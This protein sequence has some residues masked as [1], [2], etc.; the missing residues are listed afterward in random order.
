[1]W[2]HRT[3]IERLLDARA[4]LKSIALQALREENGDAFVKLDN[5]LYEL[6]ELTGHPPPEPSKKAP[7]AEMFD[8]VGEAASQYKGPRLPPKP[9]HTYEPPIPGESYFEGVKRRYRNG[10]ITLAN[11]QSQI[12]DF[13][14]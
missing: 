7:V 9:A 11:V 1:M 13:E 14:P 6:D 3:L 2:K 10:E 4:T 8:G 12:P 5:M